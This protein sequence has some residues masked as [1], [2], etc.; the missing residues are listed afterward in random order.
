DKRDIDQ[1]GSLGR[2]QA[3]FLPGPVRITKATARPGTR[4]VPGMEVAQATS[5][6]RQVTVDL[7][8]SQQSQVKVGDRAQI[9]LPDN[10]TTP[11]V[12]QRIGTVASS[13]D[14]GSGPDSGSDSSGATLPIHITL[15]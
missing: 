1:T 14:T 7:S 5:T 15:K 10:R 8:A 6:R 3:V 11:G 2:G 4:A 12:V 13:S 9:T